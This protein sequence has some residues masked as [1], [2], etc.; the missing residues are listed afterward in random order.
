MVRNHGVFKKGDIQEDQGHA[1][2]NNIINCLANA[3]LGERGETSNNARTLDKGFPL[4]LIH[5]S[6]PTRPY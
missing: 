6:E 5:I 4:S 3:G 2:F 1:L